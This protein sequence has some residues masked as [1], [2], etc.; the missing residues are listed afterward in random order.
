VAKFDLEKTAIVH[1]LCEVPRENRDAA[2]R[3][4]F[5]EVIPDASMQSE[6]PQVIAGPDGFPYV[7]LSTPPADAQFDAFCLNHVLDVCLDQGYGIVINPESQPQPDFVF[8]YGAL[9][10]FKARGDFEPKLAS[11]GEAKPTPTPDEEREILVAQPS[12]EYLPDF[13]RAAISRFMKDV[14]GVPKPSC[15]MVID[16]AM[17]P[18]QNLVF[19]VE[20][21]NFPSEDVFGQV[22]RAL[23]WFMPRDYALV[24]MPG[25]H[26]HYQPLVP[27]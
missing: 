20:P 13:A 3:R 9:W 6:Q 2:W 1:Q 27:E 4:K 14:V 22:M 16:A 25:Q 11:E 19:N 23:S 10:S 8:T 5:Y 24:V 7:V 12:A 18:S 21:A 15:F 17:N 26:E